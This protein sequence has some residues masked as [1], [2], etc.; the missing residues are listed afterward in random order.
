MDEYFGGNLL[1]IVIGLVLLILAF[2]LVESGKSQK[3]RK[4]VTDLYVAA[5]TRFFAKEDGLDLVAEEQIYKDWV[6]RD[7]ASERN[8]DLDQTIEEELKERV[9]QPV[10]KK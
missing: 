5:K 9:S 8:H 10:K 7:R 6:K 2:W 3:Y 1:A 4:Y